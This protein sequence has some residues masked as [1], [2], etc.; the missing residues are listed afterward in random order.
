VCAKEKALEAYRQG[1]I[2]L[3]NSLSRSPDVVRLETIDPDGSI[4][5]INIDDLGWD[6]ADW[7]ALV[8]AYPYAVQPE[9]QLTSVL[10]GATAT[11]LAHVRADW[12][13]FTA[14]RPG[15]YE[16]LLKLPKTFQALAKEQG[17]DVDANIKKFLA[18]RSGFQKSGVSQ[19]NRLIERHPSRSGYFW[20]SYD[21]AG[22]KQRQSLFEHPNGP[23]V[24]NGF[25]HDGG[26]TIYSLP[27]GFQAYYLNTAKGDA[28]DKGPTNIVRDLTRKD[29]TVTNGISCMGCHDQGMRKAKDEVRD[30]VVKSRTHTKQVREQVE[31]MHVPPEKMDQIIASDGKRFIEAMARA[32]LNPTL[33]LNGVEMTNALS[34]RYEADVDIELAAA[35]FGMKRDEFLAAAGNADKKFKTIL[36]RL[37]QGTVPRDQMESTYLE[38]AADITDME[39]VKVAVAKGKEVKPQKVTPKGDLTLTSDRDQYRQGDSPILSVIAARDCFLTLTNVDDKGVGTV[40]FPNKFQQNNL[41]K[42]NLQV[43]LPGTNAFKF[44]LKDK[45]VETVIGVCADGKKEVDGIKHDFATRQFTTVQNYSRSVAQARAIAVVPDAKPVA[46]AP[47]KPAPVAAAP[48]KPAPVVAAQAQVRTAIKFEVQ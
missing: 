14:S 24:P 35:E 11:K 36:R 30:V 12:F 2:K 9:T 4:L 38:I 42:A 34:D 19:N 47:G 28:I 31:A 10:Q 25:D 32:G 33:K 43:D 37:E 45:G 26:E 17:V 7:D 3:V 18:L 41:I 44:L 8:A 5:R 13:A 48:G 15:M 39:P 22:N 6:A 27:N 46:P 23:N 21:F 16:K 29:L 20:T 1:A 40:I